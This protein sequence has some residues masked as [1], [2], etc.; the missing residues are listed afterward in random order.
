MRDVAFPFCGHAESGFSLASLCFFP[1]VAVRTE[2]HTS[3]FQQTEI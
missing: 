1:W 3:S 2:Y